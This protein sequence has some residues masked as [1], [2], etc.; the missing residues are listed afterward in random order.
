MRAAPIDSIRFPA[1]LGIRL[2]AVLAILALAGCSKKTTTNS[3]LPPNS[4][5][6]TGSVTGSNTSGKLTITLETSTPAPQPG[7]FRA[8]NSVAADGSYTPT[9]GSAVILVGTYDDA[10]KNVSLTGAGW[11]FTGVVSGTAMEGNCTGPGGASGVFSLNQGT[12]AVTVIIGT[13]AENSPGTET[14]N[15]NIS[16]SGT[17]VHG[18]AVAS[19]GGT[20]IPLD[21]TYTAA[22]GAISIVN[23]ANPTGP[24]LATGT[25]NATAGTASGTYDDGAGNAGTW[26]GAKQ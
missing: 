18:N 23:P 16:I 6:Y 14:G 4:T 24:A 20:P 7:G 17:E 1:S 12:T 13:Y 11:T 9:G 15:F 21:G 26:S 22:S 25:Y 10:G 8:H 5:T 2:V 19:T 3:N